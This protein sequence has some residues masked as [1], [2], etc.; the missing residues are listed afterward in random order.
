MSTEFPFRGIAGDAELYPHNNPHEGPR[1][2][3]HDLTLAD[4][5]VVGRFMGMT[6]RRIGIWGA[7]QLSIQ[8]VALYLALGAKVAIM[9]R[10]VATL[11]KLR[12][13]LGRHMPVDSLVCI[14]CDVTD[15]SIV[16]TSVSAIMG[17]F[18]G[19]DVAICLA[20]GVQ[21]EANAIGGRSLQDVT[22]AAIIEQM[23][24]DFIGAVN[25]VQRSEAVLKAT[26]KSPCAVL[27]SSMSS[28]FPG[29]GGVH[30]G[31]GPAKAATDTFLA[32]VA[33]D[34]GTWNARINAVAIGF[35]IGDQNRHILLT[36]DGEPTERGRRFLNTTPLGGFTRPDDVAW[37]YLMLSSPN[38]AFITGHLL[39]V[40][41]GYLVGRW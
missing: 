29:L 18:G 21:P 8:M 17:A 7:G 15:D 6:G 40:D 36:P 22:S 37:G 4:A 10:N 26:G 35:G 41:G 33:R 14:G 9:R 32:G 1:G 20:G 27:V 2:L 30:V 24:V 3:F 11:E 38:S 13:A 12:A 23:R 16:G 34:W 39:A 31:Y 25:V 5:A 19:L 28:Q